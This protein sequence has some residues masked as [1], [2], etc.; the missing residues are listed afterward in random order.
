MYHPSGGGPELT[1]RELARYLLLNGRWGNKQIVPSWYLV[2]M[3][4]VHRMNDFQ[5]D[6][7]GLGLYTNIC[8]GLSL[9]LPKD[10]L[11]LPGSD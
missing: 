3:K 1:G 5:P 10:A 9:L 6:D 7:Y 8:G 4:K 11:S 2:E